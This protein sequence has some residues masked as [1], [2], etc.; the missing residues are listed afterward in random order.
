MAQEKPLLSF[1]Q[2]SSIASNLNKASNEFTETVGTLD[3]ALQRLNV[4]LVVWVT[5]R[6]WTNDDG[7][8]VREQ[9]GYAKVDREWG[10]ALRILDGHVDDPGPDSVRETWAFNE[11]PRELR[12]RCIEGLP[13]VIDALG[14]SALKTTEAINKKL[15][16]TRGFAAAIGLWPKHDEKEPNKN[17]VGRK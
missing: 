14:Q 10:I 1:D 2:L 8:E 15:A 12:L 11:A 7:S 13:K 3:K 4:G 6:E 5:C 17:I 9:I 16:E